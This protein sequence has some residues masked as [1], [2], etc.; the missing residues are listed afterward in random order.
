MAADDQT[1]QYAEAVNAATR[2]EGERDAALAEVA[3]LQAQN[4]ELKVLLRVAAGKTERGVDQYGV[5]KCDVC[6]VDY[7]WTDDG[8]FCDTCNNRFCGPCAA[9]LM[10]GGG[11]D[12]MPQCQRCT[13]AAIMSEGGAHVQ[14]YRTYRTV[15]EV[16]AM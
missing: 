3:R 10:D 12:E 13:V 4:A 15:D 7:V 16:L 6:A 2:T 14:H 9:A 11:D 8:A 5:G 1:E